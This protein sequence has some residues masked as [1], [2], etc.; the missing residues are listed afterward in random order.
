MQV[1]L[2]VARTEDE[3]ERQARGEDVTVIKEEAPTLETF[4]PDAVFEEEA[5]ARQREETEDEAKEP[6]RKLSGVNHALL[7]PDSGL[8]FC[9]TLP[10]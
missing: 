5:L 9:P 10:G 2:N 4:N 8:R 6:T 1:S 7:C 3:A